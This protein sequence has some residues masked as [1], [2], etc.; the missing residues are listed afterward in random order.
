MRIVFFGTPEFAVASL[1]AL[2]QN[3]CQIVGVV[4]A[5]DKPAKRG[6][7]LEPT[8]VKKYALAHGLNILQPEKLKNEQFLADL[9]ALAAD[10]Q[11]IVAFRML[12]E[13]VWNMPQLGT[14][15]LHASLLPQYR[16][17]APINWAIINGETETG[18][19]TFFL[20]HEIDTGDLLLQE[21]ELILP[22]DN[23]ATLHDKLMLRGASLVLKTV[24]N[25]ESNSTSPKAQENA[26][27]L[28]NAP[29]I[30]PETCLLDLNQP[31]LRVH[32][33]V[34]GLA[35]VPAARIILNGKLHK[36]HETH[37]LSEQE[38]GL[39]PVHLPIGA[40]YTDLKHLFAFKCFDKWLAVQVI[41]PEGKKQM[42]IA[43]FLNGQRA[44]QE[45]I[46]G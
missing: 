19:T 40:V 5:P 42:P 43:D 39:C 8:A 23:A 4:T 25:I 24:R 15:N 38:N 9:R 6:N 1:D 44:V 16:G 3:G 10:L 30:F 41:Q 13:V 28:K 26:Q 22:S 32:N 34:R 27:P 29:K 21:K 14:F 33:Q 11:I 46:V 12:P 20:K 37:L 35:P 36:I 45:W 2:H 7:S 31:A 17:A 18:V